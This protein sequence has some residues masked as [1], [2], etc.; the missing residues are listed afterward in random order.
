VSSSTFVTRVRS[1]HLLRI[2]LVSGGS[3]VVLSAIGYGVAYAIVGSGVL[4]NT[5]VS[6]RRSM[7]LRWGGWLAVEE[8]RYAS[9]GLVAD[10]LTTP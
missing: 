7:T 3:L 1:L 5:T 6:R 4:P 8:R 2:G 10:R 9:Q